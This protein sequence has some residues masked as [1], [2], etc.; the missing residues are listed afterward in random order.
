MRQRLCSS[1]HI[2]RSIA[3]RV[4][5]VECPCA[6]IRCRGN[7]VQKVDKVARHHMDNGWDPY[8]IYPVIVSVTSV[9]SILFMFFNTNFM[10]ALTEFLNVIWVWRVV[11]Y[12]TVSSL[13]FLTEFRMKWVTFYIPVE[14]IM[15]MQYIWLLYFEKWNTKQSLEKAYH[16]ILSCRQLMGETFVVLVIVKTEKRRTTVVHNRKTVEDNSLGQRLTE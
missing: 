11:N 7:V 6:C 5:L 15:N 2:E 8:L 14:V 12:V 1:Y 13:L 16:A 4:G 3:N 9:V 10:Y